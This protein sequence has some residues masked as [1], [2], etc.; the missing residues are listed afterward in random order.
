MSASIVAV[1]AA[2]MLAASFAVGLTGYGFGLIAMGILPYVMPVSAANGV[3]VPLALVVTVVGIVPL[4][5]ELRFSILWPLFVGAAIGVPMGVVY[6]VRL[7]EGVLRLSLGVVI[8]VAL[9]GSVFASLR[10]RWGPPGDA[11][12]RETRPG[13]A[14]P[15]A[16]IVAIVV[17]AV[18]GAFGGA[19]SVSGP[20]VVLY[21]SE[22][23][24]GKRAVKAHLLAY[25]VFV[26]AAR[27]P[28]LAVSGVI[29][30]ETLGLGAPMLPVVGLG[31]WMGTLLHDRLPAQSVRRIIQALLAVSATLLIAG[32]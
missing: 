4:A 14:S 8:L 19:F 28:I 1:T 26:V 27:L 15:A 5:R 2:A 22:V 30:R 9:A 21:F 12:A 31:L 18:S 7:N 11:H 20:P 17:G 10:A 25:F 13:T 32:V 29:N 24:A 16:R 23:L 6:L 3:V